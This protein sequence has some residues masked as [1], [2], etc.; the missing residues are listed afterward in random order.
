MQISK[1]NFFNK[2]DTIKNLKLETDKE[3]PLFKR[4]IKEYFLESGKQT[5]DIWL[6][7]IGH[8]LLNEHVNSVNCLYEFNQ[9]SSNDSE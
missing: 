1:I 9:L 7:S 4:L 6:T 3:R 2:S 8:T 5:N